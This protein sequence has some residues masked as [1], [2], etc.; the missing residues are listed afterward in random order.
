MPSVFEEIRVV[1]ER[2][3]PDY[4]LR[5]LKFAQELSQTDQISSSFP[6]TSL[7]QGT[8]GSDLLGFSLP[9]EDAEAIEKALEDCERI[10]PD[11]HELLAG[12]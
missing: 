10:D 6:A 11:E 9:S 12:L 5:V 3:S 2:L 8:P 7:P 4:Q 1:V